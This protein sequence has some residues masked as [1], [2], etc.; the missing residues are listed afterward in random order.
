MDHGKNKRSVN[1]RWPGPGGKAKVK[2]AICFEDV[3][4]A[5]HNQK[6]GTKMVYP[7]PSKAPA[8]KLWVFLKIMGPTQ[9]GKLPFSKEDQLT[10]KPDSKPILKWSRTTYTIKKKVATP[11]GA[12]IPHLQ[13]W[14]GPRFSK[15]WDSILRLS[16]TCGSTQPFKVG[17]HIFEN[18]SRIYVRL[19]AAC[20]LKLTVPWRQQL[21]CFLLPC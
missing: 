1:Q 9:N 12:T 20:S 8:K 7:E 5:H 19:P 14:P 16:S 6:A 10:I 4:K 3:R 17:P 11:T 13:A 2:R 15:E 21:G 18:R